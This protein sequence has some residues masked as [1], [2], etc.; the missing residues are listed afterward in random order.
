MTSTGPA[1][2]RSV[3]PPPDVHGSAGAREPR[4]QRGPVNSEV[5]LALAV[6]RSAL[7]ART[8]A[9]FVVPCEPRRASHCWPSGHAGGGQRQCGAVRPV[10][11]AVPP[12]PNRAEHAAG[13]TEEGRGAGRLQV[14]SPDVLMVVAV[15]VL[16]AM[17]EPAALLNV[18]SPP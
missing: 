16:V 9:V 2:G 17:Q 15:V 8:A 14:R 12:G 7:R 6:A 1:R 13:A 10:R 11:A 4:P 18:F 5:A 3:V